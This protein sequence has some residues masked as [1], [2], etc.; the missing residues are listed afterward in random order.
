MAPKLKKG[1]EGG[2]RHGESIYPKLK[3]WESE[4][5]PHPWYLEPSEAFKFLGR[6]CW[7]PWPT[8]GIR[9]NWKASLMNMPI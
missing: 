1:I 2:L 6:V 9:R 4:G 5:F 8:R 7:L 3:A